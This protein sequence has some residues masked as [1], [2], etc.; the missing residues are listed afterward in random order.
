MSVSS[1]STLSWS[2][3]QTLYTNLNTARTKFGFTTVTIPGNP[4]LATPSNIETLNNH[5]NSMASNQYLRNVAVTGVTV[6]TR[7]TLIKPVESMRISATIDAIN[8]TCAFNSDNGFR[9][10][11][12]ADNG[13]RSSDFADN[14]FR[15][16][17]FS[18]NGFRSSNFGDNGF[19]SADFGNNTFFS[20]NGFRSSD[21][22]NN[23]FFSDNGFRSSNFSNNGFRSSVFGNNPFRSAVYDCD[24]FNSARFNN[25]SFR[26]SCLIPGTLIT[27]ADYTKKKIEE[28]VA[29]DLVLTYNFDRDLYEPQKVL[30]VMTSYDTVNVLELELE[31]KIKLGITAN[32]PILSEQGW[33]AEDAE[34][35]WFEHDIEPLF[36]QVGQKIKIYNGI[37]K[38]ISINHKKDIK[39]YNTYNINVKNNHNYIAND[40]IVHNAITK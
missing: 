5:V 14:G 4:G 20:D 30:E 28:I 31:D 12:F 7:G 10:S 19:R 23:G 3:I 15:S 21:F 34:N 36:M 24:G 25:R 11:D 17:D 13:F 18:D 27:M 35:S 29:G 38:L 6:P 39:N 22:G 40:I 32:H 2:D 8:N 9:S 26:G 16:S 37:S 1:N 33:V